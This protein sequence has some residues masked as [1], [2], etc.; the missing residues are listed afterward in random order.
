MQDKMKGA[1]LPGN[2]T[3]VLMEF[4]IPK[5][6][7]GQ[8]LVK[9]MASGI[10]GSDLSYIWRGHKTFEGMDGPAYKGVIS[11]HEPA[12]LVVEVGLEVS[13]I[14]VGDRALVYHIAGCGQCVNCRS[15]YDIS[16]HGPHAA[17]GWQ[18]DGGHGEYVLAEERSL[19]PLPKSL[20]YEDGALVSCG[21]GT[22]YE[23]LLRAQV[24]G[25][26]TLFITGIGPVGLAVAMLAKAMGIRRI[27]GSDISEARLNFAS[28]LKLISAGVLNSENTVADAMKANNRNHFS[29]SIDCSGTQMGRANALRATA[30]WGRV[31]LLGEGNDLLI[32][33]SDTLLHRH[34]TIHASWVTS[35]PRMEQLTHHLVDWNIHPDKTITDRFNLIDI[36]KAYKLAGSGQSGKICIV[37][38]TK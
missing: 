20:S 15:G 30:E 7:I 29:V 19:I 8:V 11:G 16:C 32:D 21:F 38:E 4:E 26:D 25:L 27:V 22:A 9:M 23:G 31:A 10:C 14:K 35:L 17:Y 6:G 5:P 34:M 13:R 28:N 37:G 18:R 3:A 24:S 36:D 1:V 33:V 12:G 2:Q